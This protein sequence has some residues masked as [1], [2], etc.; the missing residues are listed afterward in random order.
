MSQQGRRGSEQVRGSLVDLTSRNI[1]PDEIFHLTKCGLGSKVGWAAK[2]ND[3]YQ[4]VHKT[5]IRWRHWLPAV[6][7]EKEVSGA[8]GFRGTWIQAAGESKV[9]PHHCHCLL[10][11][12]QQY[13]RLLL[14]ILLHTTIMITRPKP[15]YGRQG[16]AGLWGQDTDQAGTF[17]GVVNISLCAFSAQLG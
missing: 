12:L 15:A 4:N 6:E 2:N 8:K 10:T 17:W 13:H 3:D 9:G 16:L 14:L 5:T 7:E 1:L 11:Q